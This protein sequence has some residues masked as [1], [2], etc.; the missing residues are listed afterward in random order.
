MLLTVLLISAACTYFFFSFVYNATTNCFVMCS[1]PYIYLQ[2][3]LVWL[4]NSLTIFPFFLSHYQVF[5]KGN[6]CYSPL[7]T[8]V[9]VPTNTVHFSDSGEL[10]AIVTCAVSA[11]E[12]WCRQIGTPE[13][14][15][16]WKEF[17]KSHVRMLN[18]SHTRKK[19]SH[20]QFEQNYLCFNV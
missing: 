9:S 11:G 14:V 10:T 4:T 8:D 19:S 3:F 20:L 7:A 13:S 2:S 15:S 17:N 5:Q 18:S 1:F 6:R 12:I 16:R